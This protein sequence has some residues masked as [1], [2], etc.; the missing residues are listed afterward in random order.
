MKETL[1]V[2]A[3]RLEIEGVQI[4]FREDPVR[5]RE[6]MKTCDALGRSLQFRP[7]IIELAEHIDVSL[8]GIISS[9]ATGIQLGMD[10]QKRRSCSHERLNEDGI[11]R[12]CGADCRRGS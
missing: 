4:D 9:I 3:L 8:V 6:F 1:E 5:M 7:F 10:L 12:Q 11:C 2:K